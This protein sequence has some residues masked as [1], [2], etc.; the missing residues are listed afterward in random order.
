MVILVMGARLVHRAQ[1]IIEIATL[2]SIVS[3]ME[4][5]RVGMVLLCH[6]EAR[7]IAL[8]MAVIIIILIVAKVL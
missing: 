7:D 8:Y 6:L 5:D 2:I 3:I 4:L 1:R